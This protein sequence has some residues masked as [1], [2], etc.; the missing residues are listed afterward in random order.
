MSKRN[1]KADKAKQDKPADKPANVIKG[2]DIKAIHATAIMAVQAQAVIGVAAAAK[3]GKGSISQHLLT[4]AKSFP[5]LVTFKAECA[6]QEAWL[7]SEEGINEINRLHPEL[8]YHGGKSPACWQ[9]AKSN[10]VNTWIHEQD[11]AKVSDGFTLKACKTE[12][13]MRAA[14][15]A[16]RKMSTTKPSMVALDRLANVVRSLEKAHK[17]GSVNAGKEVKAVTALVV[18]LT[19]KYSAILAKVLPIKPEHVAE[20]KAA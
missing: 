9:Q 17:E 5:T 19:A 4:A 18:D 1:D 12:S 20:K 6:R 10:I 8:Q 7:K 16:Y 3:Q 11:I 2:P 13:E 15:N 14:L